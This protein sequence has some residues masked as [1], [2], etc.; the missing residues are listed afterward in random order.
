LCKLLHDFILEAYM[1][2]SPSRRNFFKT[3]GAV[4]ASTLLGSTALVACGDNTAPALSS[5]EQLALTATQ[6]V[7][8]L[9]SGRLSATTYVGTLI[10]RAKAV[11]DLNAMITLDEA[12]AMA[13]AKQCRP[14]CWQN[15]GCLGRLTY[16]R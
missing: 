2:H 1:K 4:S 14:K 11:S 7:A 3:S 10:A 8:A 12:G 16:R 13:T 9:K 15:I 5:D 6:A